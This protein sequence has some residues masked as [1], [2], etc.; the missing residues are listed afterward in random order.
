MV[1]T[2]AVLTKIEVWLD[3]CFSNK[4]TSKYN[5]SR[6]LNYHDLEMFAAR[7]K[8][9]KCINVTVL[10]TLAKNQWKRIFSPLLRIVSIEIQLVRLLSNGHP[11]VAAIIGTIQFAKL[12]V[13]LY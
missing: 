12:V 6:F 2:L 8:H 5:Y 3:G 13:L 10:K 4:Y 9:L 7:N 11:C 1:Y